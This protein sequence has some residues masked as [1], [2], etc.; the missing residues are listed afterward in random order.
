V[1]S[2]I[3]LDD[4][5]VLHL[6]AKAL[7]CGFYPSGERLDAAIEFLLLGMIQIPVVGQTVLRCDFIE[8]A[9]RRS[10]D[11]IVLRRL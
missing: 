5:R 4:S 11:T 3:Q 1:V 10:L 9:E 8:N 7:D 6:W 2:V